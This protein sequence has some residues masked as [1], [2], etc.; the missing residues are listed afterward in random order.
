[1]MKAAAAR[2]RRIAHVV[3]ILHYRVLMSNVNN[4]AGH[5]L[6]QQNMEL[7]AFRVENHCCPR[8]YLTLRHQRGYRLNKIALH[9]AFQ[10]T[11]AVFEAGAQIEQLVAAGYGALQPECAH[12][13]PAMNQP[14]EIE[15]DLVEN[16]FARGAIEWLIR[17]YRIDSIDEF[18][19]ELMPHSR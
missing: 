6:P 1:M 8:R 10:L 15:H 3:D 18:R 2:N 12:A 7:S 19:R 4:E 17:D 16:H 13:H 5:S 14:R 11:R 9:G